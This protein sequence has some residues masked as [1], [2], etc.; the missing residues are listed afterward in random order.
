M[1]ISITDDC[2]VEESEEMFSVHLTSVPDQN[3]R[4]RVSSES[5]VITISDNDG[6]NSEPYSRSL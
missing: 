6:S 4:I 3:R 1:N 5:A 2:I